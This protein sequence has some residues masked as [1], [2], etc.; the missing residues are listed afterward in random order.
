MFNKF[1]H[2]L[3]SYT[4]QAWR[5][6]Q[7]WSSA[8]IA[9]KPVTKNDD[10][11]TVFRTPCPSTPPGFKRKDLHK[12]IKDLKEIK[13]LEKLID[14]FLRRIWR[15]IACISCFE[16]GLG[17]PDRYRK[18][19]ALVQELCRMDAGLSR[20]DTEEINHK[21]L[22]MVASLLEYAGGCCQSWYQVELDLVCLV[23]YA[24]ALH[25]ESEILAMVSM[26][27]KDHHPVENEVEVSAIWTVYE[28]VLNGVGECPGPGLPSII[29]N[30]VYAGCREALNWLWSNSWVDHAGIFTHTLP[31]DC[32]P[33]APWALSPIIPIDIKPEA[34]TFVRTDVFDVHA[35]VKVAFAVVSLL[36][37]A[38]RTRHGITQKALFSKFLEY[39]CDLS[40]L[41]RELDAPRGKNYRPKEWRA[42]VESVLDKVY[43]DMSNLYKYN[44]PEWALES[45]MVHECIA[46]R[47]TVARRSD[48]FVAG[49]EAKRPTL[50]P[51]KNSIFPSAQSNI[52]QAFKTTCVTPLIGL[53]TDTFWGATIRRRSHPCTTPTAPRCGTVALAPNNPGA[54]QAPQANDVLQPARPMHC[55]SRLFSSFDIQP[56]DRP[57]ASF[58]AISLNY[59]PLAFLAPTFLPVHVKNSL[60]VISALELDSCLRVVGVKGTL[61]P[62]THGK[63]NES[64]LSSWMRRSTVGACDCRNKGIPLETWPSPK[65]DRDPKVGYL[66]Q[67]LSEIEIKL[68]MG[69][70]KDAHLLA[71]EVSDVLQ[72]VCTKALLQYQINLHPYSLYDDVEAILVECDLLFHY[73][74]LFPTIRNRRTF[75][76]ASEAVTELR[77]ELKFHEETGHPIDGMFFRNCREAFA[78]IWR[79]GPGLQSPQPRDYFSFISD[80]N[81]S[82]G[83]P[84]QAP[85]HTGEVYTMINF[86]GTMFNSLCPI[87]MREENYSDWTDLPFQRQLIICFG[88]L[89]A[90]EFDYLAQLKGVML[91]RLEFHKLV[92]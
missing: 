18:A 58:R 79:L 57:T 36:E 51:R 61:Y 50:S 56:Q 72:L 26:V 83:S 74:R 39:M 52:R 21:L 13:D 67:E 80:E 4:P 27:N 60:A 9:H 73:I 88:A 89:C 32:D 81:P 17:T 63:R 42:K 28:R 25:I 92:D 1:A 48:L 90:L 44:V 33:P 75:W 87:F 19:L 84:D 70:V 38:H 47:G 66:M 40:D 31:P 69:K 29:S 11:N 64:R 62:C 53:L 49:G 15:A 77:D 86:V 3:G 43:Q 68:L 91:P 8:R 23:D 65:D 82:P 54:E 85:L 46:R 6:S 37:R 30:R 12:L 5:G 76:N 14:D 20:A 2:T 35:R 34:L 24:Q 45:E 41:D 55:S 71:G 10:F 16:R 59:V 78:A 22:E 7:S